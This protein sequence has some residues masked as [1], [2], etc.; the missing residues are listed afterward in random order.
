LRFLLEVVVL[1]DD[2]VSCEL[3]SLLTGKL[4]GNFASF[5]GKIGVKP[6]PESLFEGKPVDFLAIRTGKNRESREIPWKF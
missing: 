1:A 3:L 6:A 4:T 2:A 5:R